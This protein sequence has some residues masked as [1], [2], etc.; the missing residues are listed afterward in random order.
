MMTANTVW[1]VLL[2]LFGAAEAITVG[3]TSIWFALGALGA[4]ICSA[5]GGAVWLQLTVFLAV[6]FL[7][8]A[9]VR[10]L[11]KKY[12][13]PR[14]SPTNADRVIGKSAVVTQTIDNLQGVGQVSVAG[15]S[16]T[17][18]SRTGEVIPA[19]TRVRVLAIEGVKVFVAPETGD[20]A[21]QK[22]E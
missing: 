16:W 19:D 11:S 14:Y 2:I 17:A 15:Q 10:P 6:S 8:L 5:L 12:L 13:S 7:T 18:R 21:E 9:L 20:K 4:L 1:M 22:E 3:L